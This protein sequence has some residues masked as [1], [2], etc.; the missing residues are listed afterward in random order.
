[1]DEIFF[2]FKDKGNLKNREL[3]REIWCTQRHKGQS[4][5]RNRRSFML[6]LAD[7]SLALAPSP[8][9]LL[10]PSSSPFLLFYS[11]AVSLSPSHLNLD[12]S[13]CFNFTAGFP[14]ALDPFRAAS[15]RRYQ[16][17]RWK[18][19]ARESGKKME[20]ELSLVTKTGCKE[21]RAQRRRNI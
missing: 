14:L 4:H 15:S 12:P 19:K 7:A 21:V 16:I 13:S 17:E 9:S 11:F 8:S 2:L 10:P 5:P 18:A 3:L 6:P 20:D 1:M